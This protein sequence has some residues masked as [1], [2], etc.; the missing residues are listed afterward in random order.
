MKIII[1]HSPEINCAAKKTH[2]STLMCCSIPQ[3]HTWLWSQCSPLIKQK[4]LTSTRNTPNLQKILSHC[5]VPPA[6]SF[7]EGCAFDVTR[8]IG[9]PLPPIFPPWCTLPSQRG[10]QLPGVFNNHIKIHYFIFTYWWDFSG[11]AAPFFLSSC[12]YQPSYT[13]NIIYLF[14]HFFC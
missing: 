10:Q 5:P 4:N 14:F 9:F 2:R 11:M 7:H 3:L 1:N 8:W 13:S 12:S 6:C